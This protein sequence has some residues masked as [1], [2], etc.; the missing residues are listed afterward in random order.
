MRPIRRLKFINEEF[1][2]LITEVG[3]YA[4]IYEQSVHYI[5]KYHRS[6]KIQPQT[7]R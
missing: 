2:M 6:L 7:G 3:K 4:G 5:L 1:S